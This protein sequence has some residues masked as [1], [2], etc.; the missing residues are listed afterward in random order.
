MQ[1]T[2]MGCYAI[3]QRFSD[4]TMGAC[5]QIIFLPCGMGISVKWLYILIILSVRSLDRWIICYTKCD[6]SMGGFIVY[7][8]T[9]YPVSH[10][11]QNP[12]HDMTIDTRETIFDYMHF[13]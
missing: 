8:G 9:R 4:I 7:L 5:D 10:G 12:E 3:V 2:T 1:A 13:H 11:H 6:I